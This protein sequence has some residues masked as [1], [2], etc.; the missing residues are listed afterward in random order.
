MAIVSCSFFRIRKCSG[1]FKY[2]LKNCLERKARQLVSEN[3]LKGK[4][5]KGVYIYMNYVVATFCT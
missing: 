4:R 1:T 2:T 5:I 3:I